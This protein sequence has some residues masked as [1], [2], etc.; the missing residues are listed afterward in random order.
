MQLSKQ[1]LSKQIEESK[2]KI[3]EC[4]DLILV[5]TGII[6]HCNFILEKFDIPD[7]RDTACTEQ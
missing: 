7:D 3:Q 1:D 4:K 6:K 5:H 2:F